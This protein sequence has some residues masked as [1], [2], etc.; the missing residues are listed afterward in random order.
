[1]KGTRQVLEEFGLHEYP[2]KMKQDIPDK[3]S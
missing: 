2:A 1:L 3:K